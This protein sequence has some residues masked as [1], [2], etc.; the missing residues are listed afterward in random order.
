MSVERGFTYIYICLNDDIYVNNHKI[1]INADTITVMCVY[2][3]Y[4]VVLLHCAII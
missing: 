2:N 1:H 3:D 4:N